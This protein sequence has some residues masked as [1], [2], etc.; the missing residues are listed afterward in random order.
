MKVLSFEGLELYHRLA[1]EQFNNADEIGSINERINDID[2]EIDTIGTNIK[3]SDWN[4]TDP[5]AVDF[6]KNKPVILTSEDVS[7]QIRA[8]AGSGGSGGNVEISTI[9]NA[10]IDAICV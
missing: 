5:Q 4:Q 1:S 2:L 8:E 6:I 7:A 3:P 10:E 9:T